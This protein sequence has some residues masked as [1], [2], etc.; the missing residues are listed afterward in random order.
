MNVLQ[1]V[2]AHSHAPNNPA[3]TLYSQPCLLHS[4]CNAL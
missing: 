3:S 2:T 1:G 4:I